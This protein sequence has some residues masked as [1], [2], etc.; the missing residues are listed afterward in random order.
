MKPGLFQILII[1]LIVLVLFGRGR[2][3]GVMGEFGRGIKGFRKGLDE[4]DAVPARLET[5]EAAA[6]PVADKSVG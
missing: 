6:E 2:I 4:D 3:S 5:A 1:L